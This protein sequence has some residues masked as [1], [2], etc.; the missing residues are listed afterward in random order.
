[1]YKSPGA[2]PVQVGLDLLL[3]IEDINVINY[4]S[5]RVKRHSFTTSYC[6]AK[7]NFAPQCVNWDMKIPIS[8]SYKPFPTSKVVNLAS[9]YHCDGHSTFSGLRLFIRQF[10]LSFGDFPTNLMWCK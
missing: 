10:Q 8:L 7:S 9:L 1:M 3:G 6:F 4:A 5:G 2:L